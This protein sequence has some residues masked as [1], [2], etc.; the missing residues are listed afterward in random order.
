MK[1]I[2]RI[3]LAVEEGRL[4]SGLERRFGPLRECKLRAALRQWQRP[5]WQL[6]LIHFHGDFAASP[7]SAALKGSFDKTQH[8][9]CRLPEDIR[10]I[11]GPSGQQYRSFVNNLVRVYPDPHYLEIG[12]WRGSTATAALYGNSAH[13]LCIDN[14]SQFG[15]PRTEFFSNMDKV[16]SDDIH[17]RFFEQDFRSVD[18]RSIGPFNIYLFDGPHEE[19]DQYHGVTL[20]QPAL[21]DPFVLI[22]DDWNW[23]PVRM[24]TF[25]GLL[26]AKCYVESSIEIRT[27]RNNTHPVVSGKASDWHNGYFLAVV[28]KRLVSGRRAELGRRVVSMSDK[29]VD[30]L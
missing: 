14:W 26:D 7:E 27:T 29:G 17:F 11:E 6:P 8:G 12:S 24:G 21:L 1:T 22:V 3:V 16:I 18:F 2:N 13:A 5:K 28:R 15:G 25:R 23:R 4:L 9:T 20:A 19:A 30:I 10:D